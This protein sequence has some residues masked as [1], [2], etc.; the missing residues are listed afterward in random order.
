MEYVK[1]PGADFEVSRVGMGGNN[2]GGRLNA[3][4][5]LRVV[6]AALA[7]GIT[8]FDTADVYGVDGSGESYLGAAVKGRRD[9]VIIA[10]KCGVDLGEGWTSRGSPAYLRFSVERSLRHLQ[11]DYIDILYM[12]VPDEST[13]IA[14][15]LGAMKQLV[16]EGKIRAAGCSRFTAAMIEEAEEVSAQEDVGRFVVVE[17]HYSLLH[18]YDELD[19]LPLCASHGLA[20]VPFFPLE[21]GLLT[22]KYRRGEAPEGAR[23][24][25]GEIDG[26]FFDYLDGLESFARERG[27]SLL[28]FALAAAYAQPAVTS[29]IAGA[30]SPEQVRQNVASS[31]WRLSDAD[32]AALTALEPFELAPGAVPVT[33]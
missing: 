22:G 29:I 12:H 10:T 8:L 15:S 20:Y 24:A 19:I 25:G 18:R 32:R 17:S 28:E 3:G 9:E 23:L 5:T 31:G 7:Q 11:T 6:E 27:H 33:D 30:T 21:A 16:D 1:I 2:F 26:T 14:E 13:P 4:E